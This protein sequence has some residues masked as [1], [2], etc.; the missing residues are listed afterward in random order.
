[1][2]ERKLIRI[3]PFLIWPAHLYASYPASA[4]GCA[5]SSERMANFSRLLN[6]LLRVIPSV[7]I[8]L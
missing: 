1:L 4:P 3:K 2:V 5:F 8:L 6:W 7:A